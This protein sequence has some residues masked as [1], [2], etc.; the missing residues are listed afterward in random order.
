MA[1]LPTMAETNNNA[2]IIPRALVPQALEFRNLLAEFLE[3]LAHLVPLI[4]RDGMI[5]Q[6]LLGD[7]LK[8]ALQHPD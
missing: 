6:H 5:A 1:L 8:L 4:F 2:A 7:G 3:F